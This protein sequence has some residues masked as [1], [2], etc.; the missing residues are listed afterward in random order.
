ML[1][2][3]LLACAVGASVLLSAAC[4][5]GDRSEPQPT[6][7]TSPT[8][9]AVEPSA[10][11]EGDAV[12]AYRG[13]WDAFVEAGKVSDPDAPVLRRYASH[14][15]LRLIVTALHTNRQQKEVILGEL[16]IDP[17]VTALTP[18]GDP[19][20]ATILDCVNDEKWLE[21]KASGGLVNDEPG[22]R[23]RTTATVDRTAEGWRVSSFILEE[24]GTC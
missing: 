4:N 14:Q 18:A 13:M 12:A 19:T 21:H 3:L 6:P 5:S 2:R 16:V 20:K 9:A 7:A 8:S 23:H 10:A 24:A 17:K 15:A 11:A 1:T 22:G